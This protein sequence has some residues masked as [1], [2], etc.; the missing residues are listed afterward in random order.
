MLCLGI[1]AGAANL[2]VT[3]GH[4]GLSVR[5]GWMQAAPAGVD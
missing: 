3:Y 4:D 1:G 2:Q 5:T